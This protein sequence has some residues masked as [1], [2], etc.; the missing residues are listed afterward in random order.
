MRKKATPP[1]VPTA[2]APSDSTESPRDL[3]KLVSG[4]VRSILESMSQNG[5][6]WKKTAGAAGFREFGRVF[7]SIRNGTISTEDL[8]DVSGFMGTG[9]AELHSAYR[10]LAMATAPGERVKIA[11][12]LQ[13]KAYRFQEVAIRSNAMG[14]P[15]VWKAV[16]TMLRDASE[17]IGIAKT[18]IARRNAERDPRTPEY[19]AARAL[20]REREQQI[21]AT[22]LASIDAKINNA[23]GVS[24]VAPDSSPLAKA[25]K[26]FV[27]ATKDVEDALNGLRENLEGVGKV[28]KD[29]AKN[30]GGLLEK[31]DIAQSKQ[32]RAVEDIGELSGLDEAQTKLKITQLRRGQALGGSVAGR[33]ALSPEQA[34]R[35]EEVKEVLSGR[36]AS[37]RNW[38]QRLTSGMYL[39][40]MMRDF[41]LTMQPILE[42]GDQEYI[43]RQQMGQMMINLS[44]GESLVS[45]YGN[46]FRGAA[47][48]TAAGANMRRGAANISGGFGSMFG[49]AALG[50]TSNPFIPIAGSAAA[51]GVG[52]AAAISL[53]GSALASATLSSLA[54]PVGIGVAALS[55]YAGYRGYADDVTTRA[56]E[57]MAG[58]SWAKTF[59]GY[60]AQELG[61]RL[62]AQYSGSSLTEVIARGV[63]V[64]A[65]SIAAQNLS[66]SLGAGFTWGGGATGIGVGITSAQGRNFSPGQGREAL[67][68]AQVDGAEGFGD[69]FT[70]AGIYKREDKEA[71]LKMA[72][73]SGVRTKSQMASLIQ[74]VGAGQSI[75]DAVS[76]RLSLGMIMAPNTY[77]AGGISN[78]FADN[79]DYQ[80]QR[81]YVQSYSAWGDQIGWRMGL[82]SSSV[83]SI[84]SAAGLALSTPTPGMQ[85][86]SQQM[87]GI[88][89]QL[90]LYG[91]RSAAQWGGLVDRFALGGTPL[92]TQQIS[93][94]N[95]LAGGDIQTT[96]R[97][98][99]LG[100]FLNGQ[101]WR[102]STRA[103]VR[104]PGFALFQNSLSGISQSFDRAVS[105]SRDPMGIAKP[106]V[107]GMS[108]SQF[109]NYVTSVLS[110][111]NPLFAALA[112]SSLAPS[113]DLMAAVI[114]D[115]Y[116]GKGGIE[117]A[118]EYMA[119]RSYNRALGGLGISQQELALSRAYELQT[120]RPYREFGLGLQWATQ[121]GG[122]FQGHQW[123]GSFGFQQQE[124][125]FARQSSA[126]QYSRTLQGFQWEWQGMGLGRQGTLL[127]R[128]AQAYDLS[129]QQVDL[130]LGHLYFQQDWALNQNKRQLQFGWQMEDSERNIRRATGF[131]KQ[132]LIRERS[133]A[134]EMYNLDSTQLNRERSRE[135]ARFKREEERWNV[136]RRRFEEQNA[137][138][139]KRWAL[140]LEQ[141]AKRQ[142]WAETDRRRELEAQDRQQKQYEE[143]RRAAELQ[144]AKEKERWEAEKTFSD[145]QYKLQ[146]ARLA[147]QAQEIQDNETLRRFIDAMMTEQKA[148]VS[149][150]MR[151]FEDNLFDALK[152]VIGVFNGTVTTAPGQTA[153]EDSGSYPIEGR[154]YGG[155]ER[156]KSSNTGGVKGEKT[157]QIAQ[158]KNGSAAQ[159]QDWTVV[160]PVELIVDGKMLADA[161]IKFGADAM[162]RNQ[163]GTYG[164]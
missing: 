52:A 149:E 44:G 45:I 108:G 54:L 87:Q 28:S 53:T 144:F 46:S 47:Q 93:V 95:R 56:G 24:Q 29:T 105:W 148:R 76:T 140:E 26:A 15:E 22:E 109:S 162:R 133:R 132:Q 9:P 156:I 7:E 89:S 82:G 57:I 134:V 63:S 143:N 33:S 55:A 20:E 154:P 35:L 67:I 5:T 107:P 3:D 66:S 38:A 12:S 59:A 99:D 2:A 123:T 18:D 111:S 48:L 117:G 103:D 41:R 159:S 19:A 106:F 136:Q 141:F 161:V 51:A 27:E 153:P 79:L 1:V 84:R 62:S 31:L 40:G 37:G 70:A 78:V 42:A 98:A 77:L 113:S 25:G 13:T 127:S 49:S 119:R 60:D 83:D 69:L 110:A 142:E 21:Q 112:S 146:Q 64:P 61:R 4:M 36:R 88:V 129:Y 120:N 71:L 139:D 135:E 16:G 151:I 130:Q 11:R 68:Q 131:E 74:R 157:P 6:R 101:D 58:N 158:M 100:Y 145:E 81:Q 50:L 94:A 104:N 122:P 102:T 14:I 125:Q 32:A 97:A 30:V 75:E 65:G 34:D 155:S 128:G 39:F 23:V 73:G 86:A 8:M 85:L 80:R 92:N 91:G 121:F 138:E 150:N 17:N 116:A 163:R 160:A 164:V 72:Y 90:S 152:F 124:L 114:G 43:R 96:A 10:Q 137:L 126:I 147:L 118:Q 115:T